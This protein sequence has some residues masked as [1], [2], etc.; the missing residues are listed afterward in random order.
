MSQAKMSYAEDTPPRLY[1][2]FVRVEDEI[3][4]V[5][6][7]IK[8]L[9]TKEATSIANYEQAKNNT[10]LALL[11]EEALDSYDG[12]KRTDKIREAIYRTRHSDLRLQMFLAKADLSSEKSLLNALQAKLDGLQSR[13]G[14]MVGEMNMNGPRRFPA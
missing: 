12:P 3:E 2:E 5:G 13:K 6:R 14:I 7:N 8:T 10:I 1:D 4:R 11:K 9:A